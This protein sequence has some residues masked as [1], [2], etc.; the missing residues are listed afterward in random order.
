MLALVAKLTSNLLHFLG[1]LLAHKCPVEQQIVGDL[2]R[3]AMKNGRVKHRSQG[4]AGGSGY[5]CYAGRGRSLLRANYGHCVRLPGRYIHLAD[6]EVQQKRQDRQ[7]EPGKQGASRSSDRSDKRGPCEYRGALIDRNYL[8]Q[9]PSIRRRAA[10][11]LFGPQKFAE[12]GRGDDDSCP[13]LYG[14]WF[15]WLT[16]HWRSGEGI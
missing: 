13:R 14:G 16:I 7:G 4:S 1:R 5:P 15:L 12:Y 11:P 6:A 3:P 10:E 8:S 9:G 2:Q